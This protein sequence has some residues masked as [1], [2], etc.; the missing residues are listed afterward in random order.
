MQKAE[1]EPKKISVQE[2]E[3]ARKMFFLIRDIREEIES[4]YYY[5]KSPDLTRIGS[6]SGTNRA[7][8]PTAAAFHQIEELSEAYENLLSDFLEYQSECL[9]RIPDPMISALVQLHYF[10]G[11]DWKATGTPRARARVAEYISAHAEELNR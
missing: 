4:N 5:Y 8:D 6:G 2:L 7:A 11:I 9:K 1:T 3:N 10:S